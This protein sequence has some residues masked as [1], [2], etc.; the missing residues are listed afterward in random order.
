MT[1]SFDAVVVGLGAVGS[2]AAYHLARGGRRVLGLDRFAPPH[3]MGSSHGGSRIIRKA[4]FEGARYLPLIE[5][6]YALWRELEAASGET[7]VRFVGGLNVGPPEG[8]VVA[9]AR[10]I[11]GAFGLVHDVLT[12]DEVQARFPAFRVPEGQVAVWEREAGLLHPEACVRAHLAQARRHGA[13]LHLDEPATAWQPDGGGVRVTTAR[14][15]YRAERLVL[16]AGGWIKA[17]LADLDLPLV[18]ERQ[19]NGWFRPKAHAA[20]LGPARCPIYLWEY[21]PD[22]LLYGFPDL[23]EGV[24]AG[25]HHHGQRVDHPDALARAVTAAD[26]AALRAVLRRL[27]PD[28]DG[29]LARAAV[30]FYTNTPDEHYLIDRHPAHPQTAFASACSGHGFKASNAVGEALADLA[31]D[32]APQVDV[33]AFRLRAF[34]GRA[35]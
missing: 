9:G 21:A 4:Y 35:G 22:A 20:Q 18:V 28:A 10:Q 26:E 19:V 15:T 5:R 11:A 16:C 2:A 32:A 14:A 7:L 24:K 12:G 6:A 23:G 27:L 29:P 25:L 31:C 17:L 30:C 8:E 1:S 34:A 3:T 13:A 33:E